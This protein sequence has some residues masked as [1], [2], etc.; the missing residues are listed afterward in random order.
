[1]KT[2]K[3]ERLE[4]RLE[5]RRLW[6]ES[7]QHKAEVQSH[8]ADAAIDGIP[9]GQPILVGHHSERRHR[10]ALERHDSAMRAR[11][12]NLDM[13]KHH[14]AKAD[15]IE[16]QLETSI[17]SD[18][19]D[20]IEAIEARIKN[21]EAQREQIKRTNAA[22]R[23]AGKP[24]PDNA[25]GWR[26]VAD[27]LGCSDNDLHK[28]RADMARDFIEREPIPAYVGQNLSGNIGRLRKRV[29]AIKRQQAN[30]ADAEAAGGVVV[31][32]AEGSDYCAVI[33]AEKPE[34]SILEALRAAKFWWGSGAWCG[35]LADLPAEV[36]AMVTP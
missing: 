27:L 29:E 7:R 33:F 8:R 9:P 1:M 25:D 19:P 16:R 2:T 31:K 3:R 17:F 18:D 28:V 21:M 15:G 11:F 24:R 35:R 32:T 20:A 34:R 23:K 30:T 36:R 13:A 26:K 5:K 10:A 6:M 4:A 12:E 14:G 22:W